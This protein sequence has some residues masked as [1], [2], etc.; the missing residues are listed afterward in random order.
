MSP[1]WKILAAAAII[2]ATAAVY[3]PAIGGTALWDDAEW[4]S[5]EASGSLTAAWAPNPADR[6]DYWP[7]TSTVFWLQRQLW[8]D[9]TPGYHAVSIVLHAMGALGV[10]L[11]L[12]ELKVPGAYLAAAVFALHPVCVASV[13]WI[14]EL[15]N[16]LSLPLYLLAIW[17]VLRFDATNRKGFYAG[18]CAAFIA[19]GLAKTSI[20]VLPAVLIGLLWWRHKAIRPRDLVRMIPFVALAG[21]MAAMTIAFQYSHRMSHF[22][23]PAWPLGPLLNASRALWFYAFKTVAPVKLSMV[24]PRWDPN[25]LSLQ[26]IA[27]L[28]AVVAV[29]VVL[30]AFRKTPLRGAGAALGVYAVS[31]SPVLG[32][33]AMSFM[34]FSFVGDHLHYAALP[35]M[36]ALVVGTSWHLGNAGGPLRRTLTVAA[37]V[38]V[39]AALGTLTYARAGVF[40][41]QRTLSANSIQKNPDAWVEH[42]NLGVVLANADERL[43]AIRHYRIALKLNADY[44]DAHDSLAAALSRQGNKAEALTHWRRAV[45]LTPHR[46]DRR[47]KLGRILMDQRQVTDKNADEAITH[48]R[49][50]IAGDAANA[51]AH[52]DLARAL[53]HKKRYADAAASYGAAIGLKADYYQAMNNLAW[54]LA[55]CLDDSVRDGRRAVVWAEQACELTQY[56]RFELLHCLAAAYAEAGR[57]AD[58]RRM[59]MKAADLAAAKGRAREAGFVRKLAQF[60]DT[61][62]TYLDMQRA[63]ASAIKGK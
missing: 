42:H 60:Y 44:D 2:A 41:S 37:A 43:E 46:A 51:A 15:K 13:A 18:A 5:G 36:I 8:G 19:A 16:T 21:A 9:E 26:S 1:K 3:A 54:I 17:L 45:E 58:A 39:V 50:A 57:P 35:A 11:V 48:L 29:A 7:L 33:F 31:L 25:E 14:S 40:A 55:T 24:Y 6:P 56:S 38:A 22:D 62:K 20:V 32:F 34:R 49:H 53:N 28:A 10:W 27:P 12:A 52:F 4:L 63:A 23:R 59:A 30:C 47:F 61:G